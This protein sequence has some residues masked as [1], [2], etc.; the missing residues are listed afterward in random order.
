MSMDPATR[1][2]PVPDWLAAGPAARLVGLIARAGEEVRV[3]GGAVRN[4][5][6]GEPPG[7]IDMAT[8]ALPE[9]VMRLAEAEGL[10]AVP[11]GIAHGTVTIVVEGRGFE[12]TT[13]RQDVETDGRHALVRFGR[14]WQADAARRD[15]TVNAMSLR[16]DGALYD[17]FGGADDL[18]AG[19]VRFIGNA[20]ARIREDRLRILRF[21]RFQA[22]V[23][24]GAPDADALA[25][26]IAERAG[27]AALSR[28][29]LRMEMLKLVIAPRAG[30]TLEVM[31]DAGLLGMVLGGVPLYRDLG[32]LAAIER[33]LGLAPDAARRLAA[34]AVLVR[35]D[36]E[37][38]RERLALSNADYRRI[39]GIGHGW[40]ALDPAHGTAAAKAVL[41]AAGPRGYRD[42]A[43]VAFAR[44][45]APIEDA[46]WQ[47]LATLAERWQAPAFPISGHDLA[48]RG[49]ADGPAVGAALARLKAAWI[50]A[51]FPVSREAIERLISDLTTGR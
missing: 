34:L 38:L 32:R 49:F 50:A 21:F 13:L 27:L 41:F 7:D 19:R 15:F 44:S 10:K 37:R 30:E 36:A 3:V 22:T 45:A 39:D 43:L 8:T 24:S 4:I 47:A 17:Y 25:A 35:E 33:A 14:D 42:R 40:R 6:I 9:A 23:G 1:H 2:I 51:D 11:T 12:V 29:R 48:A 31:A 5:L 28:E 18:A 46:G 16:A 26:C 20:V